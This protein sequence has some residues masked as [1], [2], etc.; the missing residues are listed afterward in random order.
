MTE[1]ELRIAALKRAEG[2]CWEAAAKAI[3]KKADELRDWIRL[4]PVPWKEAYLRAE[5]EVSSEAGAEGLFRLREQLRND[6]EKVVRAAAYRLVQLRIA[7]RRIHVRSQETKV[8]AT[9]AGLLASQLS[10]LSDE[11]LETLLN[12]EEG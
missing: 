4:N 12:G 8:A 10:V 1:E 2:N 3:R 5:E 9:R 7:L 6:D 11:E